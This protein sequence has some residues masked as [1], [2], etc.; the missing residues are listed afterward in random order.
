VFVEELLEDAE[1]GLLPQ[2]RVESSD[3][4]R[5]QASPA[6]PKRDGGTFYRCAR[7]ALREYIA[8]VPGSGFSVQVGTAKQ[9]VIAWIAFQLVPFVQTVGWLSEKGALGSFWDA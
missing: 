6:N 8:V 3:L 2:H 9:C 7:P 1:Y 4:R 5:C